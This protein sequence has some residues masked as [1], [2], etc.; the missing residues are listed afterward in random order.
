MPLSRGVLQRCVVSAA[1]C[2]ARHQQERSAIYSN[3]LQ[4]QGS[5]VSM[6][7]DEVNGYQRALQHQALEKAQ[8]GAP[9][10]PGFYSQVRPVL[11]SSMQYLFIS[12]QKLCT[13]AALYM[14]IILVLICTTSE[15]FPCEKPS[16]SV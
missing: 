11:R 2:S 3:V 6:L 15:W 10:P 8:F 1:T 14:S 5:E 9:H 12:T 16:G 13:A 4:A 7:L